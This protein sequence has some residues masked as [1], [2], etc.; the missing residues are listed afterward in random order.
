MADADGQ[1]VGGMVRRRR[2]IEAEDRLHHP[3]HLGLLGAPVAAHGLLDAG[4]RVLSALDSGE[5]GRD[6]DGASRLPDRERG[7]G[8]D[9]D[10]GLLDRDG[11]GSS[12]SMSVVTPSKIVFRRSSGRSDAPVFHHP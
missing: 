12:C 5:R 3:L 7:A 2:S 8:V 10:E 11:I 4:R 6:E 1:R 9:A